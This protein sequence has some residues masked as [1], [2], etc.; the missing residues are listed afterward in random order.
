[1]A[2]LLSKNRNRG[3]YNTSFWKKYCIDSSC[4]KNSNLKIR[5]SCIVL[6][7]VFY[8]LYPLLNSNSEW[9]HTSKRSTSLLHCLFQSWFIIICANVHVFNKYAVHY[10]YLKYNDFRRCG[11]TVK[12]VKSP[13]PWLNVLQT[14]CNWINFNAD[15]YV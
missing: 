9:C 5:H 10:I 6:Y 3:T 15:A 11:N 12:A 4:I 2:G 1:M 8:I 14:C 7:I 13:W